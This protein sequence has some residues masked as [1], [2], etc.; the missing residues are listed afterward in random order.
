MDLS[1]TVNYDQYT[2]MNFKFC[3]YELWLLGDYLTYQTQKEAYL[4]FVISLS[5]EQRKDL[6]GEV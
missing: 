2:V 4:L 3:G 1:P 6:K 5:Q